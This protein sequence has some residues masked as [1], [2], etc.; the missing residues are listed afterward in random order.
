MSVIVKLTW[1]QVGRATKPGRYLFK[2]G[3]LTIRAED[4]YVWENYPNA[5]FTL[6]K[7]TSNTETEA[8]EFWLG[9]FELPAAGVGDPPPV[10]AEGEA[11]MDKSIAGAVRDVADYVQEKMVGAFDIVP[12]RHSTTEAEREAELQAQH[13]SAADKLRAFATL[14][15]TEAVT[16]DELVALLHG[17][18][19]PDSIRKPAEWAI[20]DRYGA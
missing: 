11:V 1:A 5:A 3:W 20:Y 15:E 4:L 6:I 14:S 16:L 18:S 2:F 19:V 10:G 8:E 12:G 9:T 13:K 17:L 7:L